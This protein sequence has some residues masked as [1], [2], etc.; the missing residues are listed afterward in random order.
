MIFIGGAG[1]A[2][3]SIEESVLFVTCRPVRSLKF[4]VLAFDTKLS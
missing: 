4:A 3:H 1:V 2:Y